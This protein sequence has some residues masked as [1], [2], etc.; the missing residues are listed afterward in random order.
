[1]GDLITTLMV[2]H[3][4]A[5]VGAAEIRNLKT[6]TI[7]LMLQSLLLALIIAAFAGR[8]QN[9]SLYWWAAITVVS[10]VI[11]IPGMLWW[12]I[13][14]TQVMEIKPLVSFVVSFILLAIFLVAF[15]QMIHTHANFVAPTAVAAAEPT[16]SALALSFTIFVLGLYVLVIHRDAVKIIIGLN[17]IEN[18]VHLALVTLVPQMPITTKLGIVSNVVF[19]ILMLLW[20]T[21][22]IYQ[23]F[24]SSDT[25]K[26]SSL[27]G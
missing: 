3:F 22:N 17:L 7:F 16:R 18:G 5:S 19:A 23:A 20:L 11:V 2:C 14:K 21:Q 26:L 25:L 12:H 13:K 15:Y 27:K 10:K 24:G 1:M 6:S 4:L 8:S 9:Y